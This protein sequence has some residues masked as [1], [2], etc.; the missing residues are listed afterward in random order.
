MYTYSFVDKTLMNKALSSTEDLIPLKNALSEEMSHMR[1]G[2][3]P[4]LMQALQ[5]NSR[6]YKN[7]RLF[8]CEK[9]FEK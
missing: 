2:L 4:N 7:M 5:D 9:V 1:G 8:E 6:E 3:I